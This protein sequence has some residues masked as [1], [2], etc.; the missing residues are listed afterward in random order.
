MIRQP[1]E[2]AAI[3]GCPIPADD[4]DRRANSDRRTEPTSPWGAFP[5]A[6]MRMRNRRTDEH[7]QPY[8]VDRFSPGMLTFILML[9][10]G[11]LVDAALTIH[12]LH[13]GGAELNPVMGYLLG[14]GVGVFVIGKYVLT[15]IGLPVLLIFQNFYLF[16]TRFRVGYLIPVCVVLYLVLITYQIVLIGQRV[17]W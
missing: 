17:G 11:S 13:Q 14:H 9:V 4:A 10:I 5:P 2:I 6:G 15:V 12:V 16:G 7:R 1:E 8:F 3:M